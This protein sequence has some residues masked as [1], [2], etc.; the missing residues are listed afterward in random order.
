MRTGLMSQ[1]LASEIRELQLAVGSVQN[2]YEVLLEKV[3]DQPIV[4]VEELLREFKAA[5]SFILEDGEHEE[6]ELQLEKLR[7]L[8]SDERTHDGMA[9]AV[10]SYANLARDYSAEVSKID[11]FGPELFDEALQVANALRQRSADRLAGNL[12]SEQRE[13]LGLR[14]RLLGALNDRMRQGRRA[15]RF[16]FRDY[17]EI[18]AKA[19][20]DYER[21]RRRARRQKVQSEVPSSGV[22]SSAEPTLEVNAAPPAQ[23]NRG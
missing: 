2:D 10:E 14:N 13:V 17:P 22:T 3:N 16:V 1:S 18:A 5:L 4:R 12:V 15:F 23:E 8:Y 6:G 7:E 21:E 9:R 11:G 19:G 20:S